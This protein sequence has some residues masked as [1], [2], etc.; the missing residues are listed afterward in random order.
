MTKD[1]AFD[2]LAKCIDDQLISDITFDEGITKEAMISV[3]QYIQG[4]C[5]A[6]KD[7]AKKDGEQHAV[8]GIVS[9]RGL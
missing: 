7:V 8:D 1:E 3:L 6:L 5:D 9:Y 4:Y 2:L